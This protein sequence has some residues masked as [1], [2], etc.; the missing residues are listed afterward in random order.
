MKHGTIKI[1]CSSRWRMKT[2]INGKF[3]CANGP[4][5]YTLSAAE[6][7]KYP[8]YIRNDRRHCIEKGEPQGNG[9]Y[10]YFYEDKLHRTDGPAELIKEWVGDIHRWELHGIGIGVL[11]DIYV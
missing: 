2:Y 7:D 10:A 3:H 5:R 11:Y 8:E 9:G 1:G 6:P 4:A